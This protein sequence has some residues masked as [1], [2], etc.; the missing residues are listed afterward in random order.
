M[1]HFI[2]SKE[3]S[4]F[5]FKFGFLSNALIKLPLSNPIKQI[6]SS[7]F[8][9]FHIAFFLCFPS[10]SHWL[11]YHNK[12]FFCG[13]VQSPN[14]NPGLQNPNPRKM[15]HTTSL[16]FITNTKYHCVQYLEPFNLL[17][18]Y[19]TPLIFIQSATIW[20]WLLRKPFQRESIQQ[21]ELLGLLT[22]KWIVE[23]APCIGLNSWT[24]VYAIEFSLYFIMLS[25]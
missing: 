18:K 25:F 11:Y 4:P 20:D 6:N 9:L 13:K 7:F 10:I 5:F 15:F 21:F 24:N 16:F 2:F 14:L 23:F 1:V 12:S 3:E 17:C 19:M 8:H 22:I